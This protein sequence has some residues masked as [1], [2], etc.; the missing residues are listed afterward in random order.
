MQKDK[1]RMKKTVILLATCAGLLT[2]GCGMGSGLFDNNASSSTSTGSS[3]G[4]VLGSVFGGIANQNTVMGLADLVIGS[5]KVSQSE[6]Y[7]TWRYIKPAC[8]F[9]SENLLAKAGG[10]VAASQANAKLQEAYN[11]VGIDADNTYFSFDAQG[12][13]SGQIKGIPLSGSYTYNP[14]NSSIK[15]STLFLSITGYVTRTTT[16]LSYTFESKKL[17]TALQTVA[18]ISGN[19]TL[20]T[21]G[22]LSK[23]YDGIRVGF[24]MSK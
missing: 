20:Q 18:T 11:Q 6:L 14:A 21:V 9:T 4:S 23:N 2:A 19:S 5:V 16:G 8:A 22:D 10:A 13:F 24:D 7:G 17:L 12:R 1:K 3:I 15:M